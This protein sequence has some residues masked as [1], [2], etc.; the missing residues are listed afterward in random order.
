MQPGG[1]QADLMQQSL[2]VAECGGALQRSSQALQAAVTEMASREL[3]CGW[4]GWWVGYGCAWVRGP[5][6]LGAERSLAVQGKPLAS[7]RINGSVAQG[8]LGHGAQRA[9]QQRGRTFTTAG[10]LW[11]RFSPTH[12][13]HGST[14]PPSTALFSPCSCLHPAGLFNYLDFPVQECKLVILSYPYFPQASTA[15][16][17]TTD[18]SFRLLE[19]FS[20][21]GGAGM[22][23]ACTSTMGTF[24]G[25]GSRQPAGRLSAHLQHGTPLNQCG[26]PVGMQTLL[27]APKHHWP[28]LFQWLTLYCLSCCR[29]I[30]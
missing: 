19:C 7:Q 2:L 18:P 3:M 17:Q 30:S 11:P 21:A 29:C 20:W 12:P 22:C 13:P 9:W 1:S 10:P 28:P 15:S 24:A 23:A 4:V 26:T 16:G 5:R 25:F 6:C 14:P 8:L 27:G